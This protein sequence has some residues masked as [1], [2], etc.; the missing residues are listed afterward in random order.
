MPNG[1]PN[2]VEIHFA[3]SNRISVRR[4]KNSVSHVGFS[5]GETSYNF[6]RSEGRYASSITEGGPYVGVRSPYR[7]DGFY[8]QLTD[9]PPIAD[10]F[11]TF[12]DE[13]L[14]SFSAGKAARLLPS[15]LNGLWY[16]K[17]VRGLS[18]LNEIKN[19][20]NVDRK[21]YE[22][23]SQSQFPLLK[24]MSFDNFEAFRR[25]P[26][27]EAELHVLQAVFPFLSSLELSPYRALKSLSAAEHT[28]LASLAAEL[29][30]DLG[31]RMYQTFLL[32]TAYFNGG[33]YNMV[34]G[35]NCVKAA[36]YFLK[37]GFKQV[38]F[39]VQ[40]TPTLQ[41]EAHKIT[42]LISKIQEKTFVNS[43]WNL[44][45]SATELVP[46][47]KGVQF[48]DTPED[49]IYW[50]VHRDEAALSRPDRKQ[51]LRF[52]DRKTLL[53][54]LVKKTDVTAYEKQGLEYVR[55]ESLSGDMKTKCAPYKELLSIGKGGGKKT[56]FEG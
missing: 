11:R 15:M 24:D 7:K 42:G 54:E 27:P 10:A 18:Q 4:G 12:V 41:A 39:R 6:G 16:L 47:Q 1:N 19:L 29:K 32:D 9:S 40:N 31:N 14:E 56:R 20:S 28:E 45:L 38:A 13:S 51:N 53:S 44:F 17:S 35:E 46:R 25:A 50:R 37:E 55:F 3:V 52:T 5:I 49:G 33:E 26:G 21:T 2:T 30:A 36:F 43:P 48:L 8:L 23:D 34:G 22:R